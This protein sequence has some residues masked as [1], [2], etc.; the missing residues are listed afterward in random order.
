M[1]PVSTLTKIWPT[2]PETSD[3]LLSSGIESFLIFTAAVAT[4][5]NTILIGHLVM[6]SMSPTPE[7]VIFMSLRPLSSCSSLSDWGPW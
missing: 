5:A 7:E 1:G 2:W 6:A 3:H 4:E